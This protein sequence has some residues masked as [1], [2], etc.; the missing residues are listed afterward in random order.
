MLLPRRLPSSSL[1]FTPNLISPITKLDPPFWIWEPKYPLQRKIKRGLQA[2]AKADVKL[3]SQGVLRSGKTTAMKKLFS[4]HKLGEE[5]FRNEVSY[6]MRIKHQNLIQ[7]VGY[8]DESSWEAV[9][10]QE[11][12]NYTFAEIP[13]RLLCFE[14]ISNRSLD[15]YISDES[16]GLEWNLKI[17]KGNCAGLN[18]VHDECHIIHLNLKPENILMDVFI[19]WCRKSRTL[20]CQG[21]LLTSKRDLSL[22]IV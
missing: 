22:K 16:S 5:K 15:K 4:L 8:C 12:E 17:I 11:S 10:L 18:Y 20:V 13:A 9:Y 14:H 3:A 19:L 1:I 6:L 21:S 7:F 2:S